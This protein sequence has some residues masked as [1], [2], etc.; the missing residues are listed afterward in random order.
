[1]AG[2]R[3]LVL[4]EEVEMVLGIDVVDGLRYMA[5]G[6][7]FDGLDAGAGLLES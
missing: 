5:M 2:F 1:V 3:F 6:V 4:Q 7:V